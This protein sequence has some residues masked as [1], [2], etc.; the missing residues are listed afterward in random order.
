[1]SGGRTARAALW[2]F[3]T[4]GGTRGVTLLSLAILA[5]L[6]APREFGLLGFALVYITYAETIGDLGTAM[7]LIYWKERRADASQITFITNVIMGVLW[8]GATLALA[9]LIAEFFKHPEAAA[10][11]R[12]LAWGFLIKFLGNTHDAL[13]QKD[14]RFRARL[15]P[16]VG[17]AVTKAAVAIALAWAG[18]GAWSLV[19]GHLAGLTVWTLGSW[20]I[21]PWRPGFVFPAGLMMPM[22]RY[23][24]GIV[25]VNVVAA[26]V[27]RADLAVVGRMLGATALGLYQLAYKVPESMITVIIWV[28]SKVLFPVFSKLE[29][30]DLRRAYL[31]AL[32]YVSL[33]TVPISA[34]LAVSA[35]PLVELVFGPKWLEAAPLLRW[36]AIYAGIRSIGTHAGD[37]LKATGRSGLLAGFGVLKGVLLV[38]SLIYA[39]RYGVEA[40]AMTLAIVTGVTALLNIAIVM[41]LLHFGLPALGSALR[42]PAIC[43]TVLVAVAIS[44]QRLIGSSD[45]AFVTI[46]AAGAASYGAALFL[47]ERPLFTEVLQTVRGRP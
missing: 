31:R 47:F 5:R 43:G 15:L 27:H 41:R 7:A 32:T 19:W 40:V 29:G 45:V 4:I 1:M 9:P 36:L 44:L 38:P 20:I 30:A 18:F 26:I 28:I 25:A 17:L 16:E 33:I 12:A 14:L 2:G 3:V 11:V 10:I 8:C 35:G 37:I 39:A 13:A 22:L 24:Q 6:L 23:G 46:V 21:V 42:A 34:V